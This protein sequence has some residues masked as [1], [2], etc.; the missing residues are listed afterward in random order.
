MKPPLFC[1]NNGI[2]LTPYPS[3]AK[4]NVLS[5]ALIMLLCIHNLLSSYDVASGSEIMPCVKIDKPLVV[6]IFRVTL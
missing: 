5:K 1:F 2:I 4:A 6:Y 3:V